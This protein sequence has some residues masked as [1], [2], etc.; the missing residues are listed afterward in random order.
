[1]KGQEM[2]LSL[3]EDLVICQNFIDGKWVEAIDSKTI[4]VIN[5]TT[6]KVIAQVP[7]GEKKDVQR[8]ASAARKAADEWGRTPPKERAEMMFALAD[9]VLR[10][11]DNLSLLESTNSGHPISVVSGE[12]RSGIDRL[13]FFGGA[14]RTLEGRSAG[15]YARGYTSIIRREPIGVAGLIT[16]WN[17]P[18]LTAITKMSPALAAGNTIVLKPSEQTPLTTLRLAKLAEDIFPAGVINVITGYGETAG[19]EMASNKDIDIISLTGGTDTGKVVARIASDTLKHVH[20]ELGGKAPALV[21]DDADPKQVAESLKWASFWN[22]GQDCSAASRVIVTKNSYEKFTAAL[23]ESVQSLIVGDPGNE[24]TQMGPL[25]HNSHNKNVLGYFSRALKNGARVLI[26]GNQMNRVGYFVEPTIM[27]D[28]DQKSEI[29]QN[30]VFGPLITIQKAEDNNQAIQMAND[31]EYGL[32]ASIYTENIGFAMEASRQLK[33]GTVW[34]NDHGAV[35]AEMPW[36]GFKQSGYGK[37]RSIYSLEDY[38]QIK[39]VMI[40][41]PD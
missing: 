12:V 16:P 1:V 31:I 18:L 23:V 9:K 21:L 26:G 41:L 20:L 3:N 11:I 35:T 2:S 5:P 32:G 7:Q 6:E 19:A 34:I 40:K 8:A 4:D 29:V 13:R 33:F 30:E 37:E 22:A 28:V 17:Y 25:T 10:D 14:G 36:G 15:E 24:S 27:T 38:T 39:H